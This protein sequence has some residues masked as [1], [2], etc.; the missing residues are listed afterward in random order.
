[1]SVTSQKVVDQPLVQ[2]STTA[3]DLFFQ[4][5]GGGTPA[6]PIGPSFVKSASSRSP[7]GKSGAPGTMSSQPEPPPVDAFEHQKP[8]AGV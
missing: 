6:L 5:E 1:M 2:V 4:E 3:P 8:P 7:T